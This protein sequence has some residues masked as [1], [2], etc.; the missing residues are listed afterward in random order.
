[1][2]EYPFA[3]MAAGLASC[4]VGGTHHKPGGALQLSLRDN[5]LDNSF[6]LMTS[7]KKY[8]T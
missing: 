5:Q 8:D 3:L 2:G 7:L 4:Q 1:M 6:A